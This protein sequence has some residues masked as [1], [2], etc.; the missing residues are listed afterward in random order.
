MTPRAGVKTTLA[1]ER[2]FSGPRSQAGAPFFGAH[3][4]VTRNFRCAVQIPS[5]LEELCGFE[6]SQ[7]GFGLYWCLAHEAQAR[8]P[9]LLE[10]PGCVRFGAGFCSDLRTAHR[11]ECLCCWLTGDDQGGGFCGDGID[12]AGYGELAGYGDFCAAQ[13]VDHLRFFQTR[14][15]ILK[16]QLVFA[17]VDA[18]AAQT[19]GVG[20]MSQARKL[21]LREGLVQLI[22]NFEERHG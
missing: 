2:A 18:K 17:F 4:L 1:M 6:G 9:V 15:V 3:C 8:V 7:F 21:R 10:P 22:G 13:H 14:S 19:I 5:W 11:Q 12:G 20:E 16:R